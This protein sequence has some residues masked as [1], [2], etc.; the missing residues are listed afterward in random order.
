MVLT[1]SKTLA[2]VWNVATRQCIRTLETGFG[3]CCTFGPEDRHAV[4]GCKDGRLQLFH[5]GSSDKLE[6]HEDAH[7]G[8]IWSLAMRPDG[9]G[10]VTG[11]AD[12]TVKF[13]NFEVSDESTKLGSSRLSL[14]HTRTLKMTDDVL[15]VRYSNTKDPT[16]LL[17]AVALLDCTVKVF[18]EDS[19]RFF[20]SLYGHKLPV[21]SM[22][23]SSDNS[24]LVTASADKNVKLWGLE[25]GD[26]H[27]SLF[28]H[29]DSV[30]SVAF[31]PKTH[32][33]FSAGK[34]GV[35]NYWDA[36]RFEMIL[37]LEGHRGEVWCVGCAHDGS[38]VLS[39]SHDR[40]VRLWE[41]TEEQV[42]LEEE[43]EKRLEEMFE[44]EAHKD[45]GAGA[46][47]ESGRAGMRTTGTVAAADSL[48]E[49]LAL[50]RKELDVWT[51][52][53]EDLADAKAA[54]G[55]T[56]K[57]KAGEPKGA[58]LVPA[59]TPNV[60]L[61]GKTPSLYMLKELQDIRPADLEEALMALPF[62]AA[63]ELLKFLL[64]WTRRGLAPELCAKCV[65][66][67][68]KLHLNQLVV[69]ASMRPTLVALNTYT[70]KSIEASRDAVGFNKAALRHFA[71]TLAP[72]SNTFGE[73]EAPVAGTES[74]FKRVGKRRRYALF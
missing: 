48:M 31:V 55:I 19:L 51:E 39:G 30:M 8:A 54:A 67:L 71:T 70:R 57:R 45:M 52:Y 63:R 10:L 35:V 14:V 47:T 29:T 41:R 13:W 26:C 61:L 46:D 42:F 33:F 34:D 3:L 23:V 53:A 2:K 60:M 25:F 4:V 44:R 38:F 21:M 65:L 32:F 66:L 56:G 24:F 22:D 11:S 16:R 28:A 12:K 59:P 49:A 17:L 68:T 15:C 1:V 43:K 72:D 74:E 62:S 73:A 7:D 9:R 37:S 50:V 64:S 27:K 20:L 6:D 69:D 58:S 18:Y 40:S 36:D 5:L